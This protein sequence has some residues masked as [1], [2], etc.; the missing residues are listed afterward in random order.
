MK[1]DLEKFREAID[2]MFVAWEIKKLEVY[3][4]ETKETWIV[5]TLDPDKFEQF[6]DALDLFLRRF[7]AFQ[8][9]LRDM[10]R[11]HSAKLM[12]NL[13]TVLDDILGK[14]QPSLDKILGESEK[15]P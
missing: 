12:V 3:D 5:K 2:Q 13:H 4:S 7:A 1:H 10:K 9:E 8:K 11:L 6:Y 14:H 15:K